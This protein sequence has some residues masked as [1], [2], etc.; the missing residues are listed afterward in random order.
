MFKKKKKTLS[1][2][3]NL[4]PIGKEQEWIT[5]LGIKLVA[6]TMV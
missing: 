6:L 3:G 2:S 4:C 1:C 5:Y